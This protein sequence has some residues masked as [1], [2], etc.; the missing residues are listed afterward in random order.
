VVGVGVN[1][2][3]IV[4]EPIAF[5]IGFFVLLFVGLARILQRI[6]LAYAHEGGHM[7]MAVA[8]LR[9][10]ISFTLEDNGDGET[11][12][13]GVVIANFLIRV[14]GYATPPLFGLAGAALLAAGNPWAV[15]LAT[16]VLS[17]VAVAASRNALAFLI[18]TLFVLGIG[19]LL[20]RGSAALQAAVAVSIVWFL[21][22][23]G[24]A[25]VF[26]LSGRKADAKLLADSTVI[27]PARIWELL[28][29]AVG[30]VALIVGGQ[31]L[32]RPGYSL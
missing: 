3:P 25:E 19:W 29:A 20:V 1:D 2:V 10:R 30:L 9:P 13:I 15:L 12:W 11:R 17:I 23:S 21:L 7:L 5:G 22:I 16:L 8:T 32:L 18:P 28:W 26:S 24:A 6:L 31:L 4:G 14:V 27:V